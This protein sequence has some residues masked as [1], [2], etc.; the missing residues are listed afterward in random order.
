MNKIV[1]HAELAERLRT[2]EHDLD[3]VSSPG[4]AELDDRTA[5]LVSSATRQ[6]REVREMLED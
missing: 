4:V 2:A 5:A 6:V 3:L 1:T